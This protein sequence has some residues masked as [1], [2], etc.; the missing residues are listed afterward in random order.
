MC[1]FY[2][3]LMICW[4]QTKC[5]GKTWIELHVYFWGTAKLLLSHHLHFSACYTNLIAIKP[6]SD[7]IYSFF[8]LHV[9]SDGV[10]ELAEDTITIRPHLFGWHK[11]VITK[12]LLEKDTC[13]KMYKEDTKTEAIVLQI[14]F[15]IMTLTFNPVP[16]NLT[17]MSFRM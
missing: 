10:Y 6:S 11:G 17:C 14:V 4:H 16:K 1:P 2:H 15:Y 5:N 7:A 9:T 3:E 13:T 8:L 12:R